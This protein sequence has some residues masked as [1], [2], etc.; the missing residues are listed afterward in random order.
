MRSNRI[1]WPVEASAHRVIRGGSWNDDARNV[2][3][4]HRN[5]NEPGNRNDNLGFRCGE[6]ATGPDRPLGN[7]PAS[8]PP[9]PAPANV[10]TAGV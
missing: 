7:R 1:R 10:Q 9:H 3:A 6:L 4:A 8:G 2:R 5:A